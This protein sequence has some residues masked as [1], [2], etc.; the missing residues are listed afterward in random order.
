[1]RPRG[2][3]EVVLCTVK[4]TEWVKFRQSLS[5]VVLSGEALR[6]RKTHVSTQKKQVFSVLS[7]FDFALCDLLFWN[8]LYVFV[9]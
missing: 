6:K 8:L 9:A 7:R 1:M 3:G 4:F 2:A 5:E